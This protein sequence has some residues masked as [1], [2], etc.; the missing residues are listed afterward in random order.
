MGR[1]GCRPVQPCRAGPYCALGAV[2]LFTVRLVPQDAVH[3]VCDGG[4]QLRK[5]LRW[6]SET[7]RSALLSFRFT[8]SLLRCCYCSFILM[9]ASVPSIF[10]YVII[11]DL[12]F[13]IISS[14]F[15][16]ST[17]LSLFYLINCILLVSVLVLSLMVSRLWFVTHLLRVLS[18]TLWTRVFKSATWI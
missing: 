5:D 2:V 14:P 8:V 7:H 13:I 4:R 18:S 11:S 9:P 17:P 6:E 10:C 1:C 16:M 15:I 3:L 12:L